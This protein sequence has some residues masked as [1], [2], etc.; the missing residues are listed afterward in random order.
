[1]TERERFRTRG[2]YYYITNDYQACVREYGELLVRFAADAAARNNLALCSTKLRDMKRAREEMQRVVEILPR[3]SLYRVN[4]SLYS[5]YAGDFATAEQE[6]M[7]AQDLQDPWAQQAMALA[8]QGG[9]DLVAATAA[10]VALGK[11]P[12]AGPSYMT[13]GLADIAAYAGRFADA[14]TLYADGA[15]TDIADDDGD[16]AAAK[17]A[18][19]AYAEL[20]RG[21]P[22][23][24]RAAAD[25]V[26]KH[27]SAAQL[28]FLSG[29]IYAQTGA[30]AEAQALAADLSQELQAEPQAYGKVLE[31]VI[32]L[33]QND[34]RLAVR[35]LQEATA[36]LDTWIGRFELGRSYLMAGA[37]PQADSEFDRCLARRGEALSLFLDEEPTSAFLPPV[38]YYQGRVREAMNSV[39]FAESYQRYLAIREKADDDPLVADIRRRLTERR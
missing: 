17:F 39:A 8:K 31:G 38:Y 15:K 11:V 3:R 14:A 12:G 5:A 22:Q 32:A 13:S 28:K 9:G 33:E 19:L 34:A 35:V 7:V 23:Q 20:A 36:L 29:R 2:M 27:S 24:A 18:G 1:M 21:R 10:Y 16:R 30:I 4:A 37:H 25:A 26:L 6:A